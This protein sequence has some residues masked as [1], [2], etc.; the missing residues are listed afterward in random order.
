MRTNAR[1]AEM[2]LFPVLFRHNDLIAAMSTAENIPQ[3]KLVNILNYLHFS[4]SRLYVLLTH[5]DYPERTLV[6]VRHEPCSTDE[7]VCHWDQDCGDPDLERYNIPYLV[8][9]YDQAVIIAPV[10]VLDARGSMMTLQLPEYGRLIN[11]RERPRFRCRNVEAEIWQQGFQAAGHLVD[12]S[13]RAFRVH[14]AAKPPASFSWFN[15]DETSMLRLHGGDTTFYAAPCNAMYEERKAR[16]RDIV[17]TPLNDGAIKRFPPKVF[18]NPR[19]NSSTPLHVIFEHPLIKKKIQ[20]EIFDISN[21]GFSIRDD[22]K[23]VVLPPGLIIPEAAVL[24]AGVVKIGCTIQVV[25]R[26]RED[27]L[28]R[29][30]FVILDMNVT[31]Y[32]KLNL[33]LTTMGGGQA[34]TSNVVD[35]DELWEFFF[36]AD[37]IYPQKYKALHTIKAD[38]RNLYRK[39][40]EESPEIA[41][42][43]VYQKNGKIYGHIAMLRAYEKTWMV[44]HH[45]A[46]P[47]GGK[48]AGLQV[49]KQLIL[50]LNDLY[51]MPSANMDH[52]ITYYR[53]GNRFPERIFGGFIDYVNDPRHASLDHF[54]YL[55]FPAKGAGGKLPDDWSVRDCTSSDFWEFEQ[56]Y[57]NSGGGLFSS[58]LMPEEGGDQPPLETVYSESGFIRRWRFH[59]LARH[60]VPQAFII[61]EESDVGINLSSL[62]NGF[63][64][65]IMQPDL[66]P[67]VLFSALS[68]MLSPDTSGSVSLLLYP[69]EYAE[70]LSSDY[71]T[72]NY[73]LWILNM[74]HADEYIDYLGRKYRIRVL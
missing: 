22:E 69:A 16:G 54:S 18:R 64:V 65:F 71:E 20:R 19:L 11:E 37:F 67:E 33:V 7:L 25:Y 38:F 9:S 52:V 39:L 48:A 56:F 59:V 70:T 46:R 68:A 45:A 74:Q 12:I 6:R 36:D 2:S 15:T 17:V 42:H 47:M 72:K 41:N 58:V 1:C 23:D 28:L 49:L 5:P 61:V 55:S 8:V 34:G 63:K 73:L 44:H 26:R 40:Y 10:R 14:V 3:K 50:Y 4:E 21:A 57:R 13:D 53:P 35:T 27:D 66:P 24:Y 60:G 30:G 43:F 51:R 62:L 32:K 29:F 31:N